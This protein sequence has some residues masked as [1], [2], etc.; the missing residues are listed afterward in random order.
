MIDNSNELNNHYIRSSVE[1][2]C[3]NLGKDRL[4][5]QGAGGNISWKIG[6]V[7]WVKASG[8]WLANAERENIFLPVD[9]EHLTGALDQGDFSVSP[10]ILDETDLRPSIETFF[11]ALMPQPIVVHLHSVNALSYL[12]QKN[13]LETIS[14]R[15]DDT[16]NYGFI[17]YYKPGDKLAQEIHRLLKKTPKTQIVFLK[18]HGIIIGGEDTKE[19]LEILNSIESQYKRHPT[20]KVPGRTLDLNVKTMGGAEYSLID[21][22]NVQQLV[23]QTELYERVAKTWAITPDHVVFLG[24]NPAIYENIQGLEKDPEIIDPETQRI[25]FVKNSGVYSTYP[26]DHA[27]LAQLLCYFDVISR[28]S[29]KDTIDVLKTKEIAELLNWDMEIYRQDLQTGR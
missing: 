20:E 23:L 24:S 16:L 10:K 22:V 11:H 18:N 1:K 7:L 2:F 8:T 9:L 27:S 6:K 12:V 15:M 13:G 25:V 14:K 19:V 5:V 28:T 17:D 3:M 4:L 21:D 29:D 26:L